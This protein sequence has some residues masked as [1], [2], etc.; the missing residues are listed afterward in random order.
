MLIIEITLCVIDGVLW[1]LREEWF[2]FRL[3]DLKSSFM[4]IVCLHVW[5]VACVEK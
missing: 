4:D 3:F 5:D 1:N 2:R